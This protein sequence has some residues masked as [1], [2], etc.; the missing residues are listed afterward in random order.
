ML[1]TELGSSARA[2]H[3]VLSRLSSLLDN[4]F[5][6]VT[7]VQ[8]TRKLVPMLNSRMYVCEREGDVCYLLV[9][10]VEYVCDVGMSVCGYV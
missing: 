6:G 3:S 7:A 1:E 9:L 5:V 8:K 10:S 4:V 2:V